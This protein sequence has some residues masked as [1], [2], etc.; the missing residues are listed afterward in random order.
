M[1]IMLSY[2]FIFTSNIDFLLGKVKFYKE[3]HLTEVYNLILEVKHY[4]FHYRST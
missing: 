4:A 1:Y 2:H 3:I